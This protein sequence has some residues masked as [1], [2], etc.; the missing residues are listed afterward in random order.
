M[1]WPCRLLDKCPLDVHGW[2]DLSAMQ[3][4]DM[5]FID[6]P[7]AELREKYQLSDY[8]WTNNVRNRKPLMI[9]L[10]WGNGERLS[11]QFFSVDGKCYSGEKGYYGGWTVTGTPPAI[12]VAPSINI[13]SSYHGFVQNGIVGDPL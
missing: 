12:T 5:Y 9:V 4:G 8:Y 2:P 1:T 13:V 3:I 7:E 11:K 10:P 6:A